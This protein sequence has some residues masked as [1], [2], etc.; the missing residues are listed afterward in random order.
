M[1]EEGLRLRGGRDAYPSN[2]IL[3]RYLDIVEFDV[4][5]IAACAPRGFHSAHRNTLLAKKQY[6]EE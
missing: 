3:N 2:E 6:N 5:R 1:R 4:S